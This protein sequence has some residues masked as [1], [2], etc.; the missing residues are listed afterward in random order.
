MLLKSLL[1]IGFQWKAFAKNTQRNKAM[2]AV[3]FALFVL[4][5][6][7]PSW[8]LCEIS[9]IRHCNRL[10]LIARIVYRPAGRS[11]GFS[12]DTSLDERT[13]QF[14]ISFDVGNV[15]IQIFF[16]I[17]PV[18][19][20]HLYLQANYEYQSTQQYLRQFLKIMSRPVYEKHS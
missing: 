15:L 9:S 11:T 12:L 7:K 10:I 17:F 3:L 1:C 20:F 4:A 8:N 6:D 2:I 14:Y 5:P 13:A 19:N 18:F 16:E